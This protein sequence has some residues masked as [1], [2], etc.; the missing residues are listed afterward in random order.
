MPGSGG[1]S[2]LVDAVFDVAADATG[3]VRRYLASV[4]GR[5]IRGHVATAVIVG[6]PLLSE[7]PLVR[8]SWAAR[9]LR[10]AAVGR[11]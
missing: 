1:T 2:G 4:Q 10:T 3:T 11:C 7:L 6:A 5:R 9:V 8:R